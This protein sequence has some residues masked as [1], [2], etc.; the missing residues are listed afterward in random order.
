MAG[1]VSLHCIYYKGKGKSS[2][3]NTDAGKLLWIAV[4]WTQLHLGTSF[5]FLNDTTTPLPHMP[6]QWFKS[7]HTFLASI[8]GC[9]KL[10]TSFLSA[11]IQRH[12]NKHIMDIVLQAGLFSDSET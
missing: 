4:S 9:L 6:G 5:G 3:Y 10:D 11:S 2:L 1:A 8:D 12:H 7:F